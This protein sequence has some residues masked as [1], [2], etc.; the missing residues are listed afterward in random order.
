MLAALL[1][2]ALASG[3]VAGSAACAPSTVSCGGTDATLCQAVA[4]LAVSR[5][6]RAATG[7]IT[8]VRLEPVEC[9]PMARS[10]FRSAWSGAHSCWS[11]E[12]TGESSHGGGYVV[13]L[14]DGHLE[15]SW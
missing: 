1:R 6:D 14:D 8:R 9:A 11:V 10:I 5:M 15:A 4:D 7:M 3:L 13:Q 2:V 12:V